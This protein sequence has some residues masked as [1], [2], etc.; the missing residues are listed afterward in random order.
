MNKSEIVGLISWLAAL[1]LTGLI[2]VL[3]GK[4]G[5]TYL[6]IMLFGL[7]IYLI[8]NAL[9]WVSESG[10]GELAGHSLLKL[11][12]IYETL[13]SVTDGQGRYVVILK[14]QNSHLI[15]CLLDYYPPEIFKYPGD[16]KN[17]FQPFPPK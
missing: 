14:E 17:P 2:G 9:V 4:G 7:D 16:E 10:I 1:L 13:S 12:A 8:I 3:I 5:Y 15:A 6:I 11:N